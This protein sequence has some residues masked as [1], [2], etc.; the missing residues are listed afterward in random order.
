MTKRNEICTTKVLGLSIILAL[1]ATPAKAQTAIGIKNAVFPITLTK[2]GHYKLTSTLTVPPG[3][4]GLV[5]A[6]GV[7]ASIDLNGRPA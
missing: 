2:S 1:A 5:L 4:D 7:D 6:D 3:V